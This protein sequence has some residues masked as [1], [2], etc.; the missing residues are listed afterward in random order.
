MLYKRILFMTILCLLTMA[1][2]SQNFAVKGHLSDSLSNKNYANAVVSILR[3]SDSTLLK[4]TRSNESGNFKITDLPTGQFILLVTFPTYADYVELFELAQADVLDFKK[5]HLS[6]KMTLL[7]EIIIKQTAI[8][9]KGDTTEYR[10]DSFRV[11]PNAS[12]EDLLK[13]LPGIQVDKEGRI[14]AQGQ[15]IQKIL[16]DGEEFFSDDPTIATRNLR[17]DGVNRVQIFDK[18]SDQ[19]SFTGIDDGETIKTINL[20]LKEDAR[21]GYFGKIAAAAMDQYYNGQAFIN[22]FKGKRK[23]SAFAIAS[24]T[25]KTG[26]NFDEN[27]SYGFENDNVTIDEG[28]GTIFISSEGGDNFGTQNYA[29]EGLPESVK[30]GLHFS[31]SYNRNALSTNGNYIFNKLAEHS[32]A[33]T[34]RQNT[35]KDSLYY[36]RGSINQYSDKLRHNLSGIFETQLDSSSSLKITAGGQA[37]IFE[38]SNYIESEAL[39]AENQL[40]N[41][42][43]R[44]VTG[45][46]DILAIQANALYRKRLKKKGRTISLNLQSKF[47]QSDNKGYLQNE[48]LF[49]LSSIQRDT[50]D[51]FKNNH[52]NQTILN[53][54]LT[55]TEALTTKSFLEFNYSYNNNRSSLKKLSYNKDQN[56]KFS[57]LIDSLSNDFDYSVNTHTAGINYRFN[58]KKYYFSLGGDIS[59]SQ[60]KQTDKV[61]DTSYK[62]DYINLFPKA[63]FNYKFNAY[64]NFNIKYTGITIQPTIH[65]LQPI[66]NNNDPLNIEIGNPNLK[67]EFENT[68][69]LGYTNYQVLNERYMLLSAYLVQTSDMIT[70]SY[71]VDSL[72]RRIYQAVNT[73]NAIGISFGSAYSIKIPNTS[74]RIAFG[75]SLNYSNYSNYINGLKN[76]APTT[77]ILFRLNMKMAKRDYYDFFATIIPSFNW[78]TSSI[79][80]ASAIKFT[81]YN[82]KTGGSLTLPAK[83]ELGTDININLREKVNKYDVNNSVVLLNAY[84]E[85]KFLKNDVLNLRLSIND[86]LNQNKG[87]DRYISPF[88]NEE[89]TFLTFKRYGLIGLTYNFMNKGYNAGTEDGMIRL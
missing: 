11:K 30:A 86:I 34:F 64:S 26:L 61:Q 58:E 22:S 38:N 1:G 4:F 3:Q 41:S 27:N 53:G 84:L 45:K 50:T 72:G 59:G 24:S 87:Y 62:Y 89:K 37:G 10:A 54:R 43:F 78:S 70:S 65:Q 66:K 32:A 5:I 16:V 7:K 12:V 56:A 46:G 18:K 42:S 29:G 13:E 21:R 88:Y 67:Q 82:F 49:Y 36:N 44:K 81:N 55:Y 2:F 73:D 6:K 63:V 19:S 40:A 77:N 75:P 79:S 28:S 57:L 74:V 20:E 48:S 85:K 9:I 51:Q 80:S 35:L 47:N 83:F 25:D 76:I 23:L 52:S 69:Q 14:T 33:N 60:F 71:Q 31:N 8:R 15:S 68:I 17:A 39:T